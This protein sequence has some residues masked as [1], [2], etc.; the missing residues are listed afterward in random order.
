MLDHSDGLTAV[1]LA[2]A[3]DTS[4]LTVSA[5]D[6]QRGSLT[7]EFDSFTVSVD[8]TAGIIRIQGYRSAGPLTGF[9]SGSVALIDFHVKDK[10]RLGQPPSTCCKTPV[11]RGPRRQARTDKGTISSSTWSRGR[12]TWRGMH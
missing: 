2:I 4:R 11:Q 1:N 9:G 6:V 5:A 3:Y 8:A 7:G 10:R 12:A